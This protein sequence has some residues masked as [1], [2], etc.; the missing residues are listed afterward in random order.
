MSVSTVEAGVVRIGDGVTTVFSFAFEGRDEAEIKVSN[1]VGSALVPVVS[2]FTAAIN[3]G[4]T[5][6]TVTFT[7]APA[8]AQSFYIFR[9]TSL[10]QLVS[11]S[12]QHK[13]DPRVVEDVWDKLTFITQDLAA[14]IALA[15]KVTPG[16]STDTL[17][18]S[19]FNAQVSTAA[20]AA[21]AAASEAIASN[22]AIAA[23]ISEDN[24]AL[25]ATIGGTDHS[26]LLNT[27]FRIWERDTPLGLGGIYTGAGYG[28]PDMWL[29]GIAGGGTVTMSRG[30]FGAGTQLG[31]SD[32]RVY[33]QQ[34]VAGHV[35]AGD[36]AFVS[37]RINPVDRYQGRQI[38][39]TGWACLP[40][41]AGNI[42]VSG[43]Q[44]F[45]SGGS[46]SVSV[47][48]PPA[49][50]ALGT[51][52]Q[53]FKATLNVPSITG[54]V[55][56]TNDDE[57]LELRFWNS[58]GASQDALTN[59]LGLQ[60]RRLQL[61]GLQIH[62]GDVAD[63]AADNFRIPAPAFTLI[64]CQRFFQLGNARWDGMATNAVNF[65]AQVWFATHLRKTP[66]LTQANVGN[67]SF[68]AT[69]TQVGISKSGFLDRRAA[70]ATAAG[71]FESTWQADAQ[72]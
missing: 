59:S 23:A 70:T 51:T 34:Q 42:A 16:T 6:G 58:A 27:D 19:I 39:I 57:Y 64:E 22:A 25:Y 49:T 1:I 4:G 38:T 68:G 54:K 48:V 8:N 41:G 52:W 9:Q 46:P 5:G 28:G 7:V 45:G 13:Y 63:S 56:G 2:G 67:T 20:D 61:W 62:H 17:L 66:I 18:A 31:L 36:Y 37:Q 72:L 43:V 11:V 69:P 50:V 32:P 12:S 24:A 44:H 29:N 71:Y 47:N 55:R 21:A 26:Y 33:L 10:T 35:N 15:I 40:D 30:T 53:K 65:A 60:N 3:P 14:D